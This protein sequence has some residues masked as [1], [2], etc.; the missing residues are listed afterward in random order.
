MHLLCCWILLNLLFLSAMEIPILHHSPAKSSKPR[1]R[2]GHSR[3]VVLISQNL[4]LAGAAFQV[5]VRGVKWNDRTLATPDVLLC[6]LKRV[7]YHTVNKLLK[8]SQYINNKIL[9]TH[10]YIYVYIYI[11]V[12]LINY[13]Y[14][15]LDLLVITIVCSLMTLVGG[16]QWRSRSRRATFKDSFQDCAQRHVH[17]GQR[18]QDYT[19]RCRELTH[20]IHVWYIC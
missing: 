13:I 6:F 12:N 17:R 7:L 5:L 9:N 3:Q 2:T 20:R 19:P 10:I 8:S 4:V 15:H 11:Y 16:G 14:V 18:I 1:S